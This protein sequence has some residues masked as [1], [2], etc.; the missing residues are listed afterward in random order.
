MFRDGVLILLAVLC[1]A[2][3]ASMLYVVRSRRFE[4]RVIGT[5]LICT[6]IINVIA[7]LA[8]IYNEGYVLDICLVFAILGFLAVVVL[9]R[10]L[11]VRKIEKV[12]DEA[13]GKAGEGGEDHA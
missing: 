1:L 7:V 2:A 8:L 3:L 9:C 12:L 4:D 5:N 11:V 13:G 10:L 6:I